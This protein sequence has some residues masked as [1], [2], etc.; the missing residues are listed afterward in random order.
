MRE[1]GGGKA[2]DEIT[3]TYLGDAR[4]N[5]GNSLL[6]MGAIA[7]ADVRIASP[8]QLCRPSAEVQVEA[9]TQA[10]TIRCP[11]HPHRDPAEVLGGSD[12]V[13]TDVWVSL[14]EPA[15]LWADRVALLAPHRST[16]PRWR[17]PAIRT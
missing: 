5:M 4:S 16:P 2:L 11:D 1:H 15:D 3:Y 12:F 13:I 6:V 8:Q 9:A 14:G 10:F 17:R 7:G